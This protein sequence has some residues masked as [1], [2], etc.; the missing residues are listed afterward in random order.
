MHTDN[1]ATSTTTTASMAFEQ[2]RPRTYN[3]F[4][5]PTPS[6]TD[7]CV[8]IFSPLSSAGRDD[9]RGAAIEG[10]EAGGWADPRGKQPLRPQ[11]RAPSVASASARRPAR[12]QAEPPVIFF[13][14]LISRVIVA[15]IAGLV[16][17]VRGSDHGLPKAG[18]EGVCRPGLWSLRH[19]L[20]EP[21]AIGTPRPI[22]VSIRRH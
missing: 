12:A 3:S 16:R 18:Q 20:H 10:Q 22:N 5:A 19:G 13:F 2:V 15:V 4:G 17:P 14:F 7:G 21:V 1:N 8:R 9:A 6:C 11:S